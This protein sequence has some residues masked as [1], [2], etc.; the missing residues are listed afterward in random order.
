MR[1]EPL[2]DNEDGFQARGFSREL[3]LALLPLLKPHLR[4]LLFCGLLLFGFSLVS[5]VGPLLIRHAIDVDFVQKDVW[6]L[7]QT[8]TLYTLTLIGAFLL[9]YFQRVKLEQVGQKIILVL[10]ERLFDRISAFSLSYFD[11]NSVGSIMSRIESDT[12]ALRMLFT[13]TV[14]TLLGDL[15]MLVS[16]FVVMFFVSW[17]LG[18]VLFSIMPVLFLTIWLYNKMGAPLFFAVRRQ[19]AVIYGLVEEYLRGMTIIQTFRQELPVALKM[20]DENEKKFRIDLKAE[21]LVTFFFNF[22]FF[23]NTIGTVLVLLF[24]SHWVMKGTITIGTLV[25]FLAYIRRFFAPIFHLSEQINVIQRAFAGAERIF[26]IMN[27]PQDIISPESPKSLKENSFSITFDHVSFAYEGEKWV[28]EDISFTIPAGQKWALVGATGS[29]KTTIINLL[30]R[31]YDPQKGRILLNGKD[32]RDLSL[33]DLREKIGLVMQDIYLF[34]ASIRDNLRMERQDI[35]DDTIMRALQSVHAQDFVL[36]D[37]A[38]LD[39]E[40]AERGKDLSL[41]ERQLLSFA[42][43]LI[44]DPEVLVLDEA[45]SS[46]D[47]LTEKKIQKAMNV[48]LKGRT[49]LIIA[50]RL[51]TILSC[52]HILV[53]HLG[54][55]VEQ[56]NHDTLIKKNGVYQKL[57]QLQHHEKIAS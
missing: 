1:R 13:D 18:L 7:L 37:S 41:G 14:V 12:E 57:Y 24:G 4:A 23:M 33:D 17:Q 20:N 15:M 34:P 5:V 8:V 32:I 9:A 27:L 45:T 36:R 25:M 49:A 11:K 30:L 6:G 48:L 47:P 35:D 29:G 43:A 53:I 19:M 10:R 28:L 22:I 52:H 21:L 54:R 31:F 50:H 16:M 56:G 51:Q 26:E 2:Y 42:R 40:L 46:V 39:R 3:F 38:G 55:I 44:R